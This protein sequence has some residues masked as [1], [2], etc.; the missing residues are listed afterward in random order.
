MGAGD[1]GFHLARI[2]A[3]EGHDITVVDRDPERVAR[4]HEHLDVMAVEGSGTRTELIGKLGARNADLLIAVTS[5]DEV[6][7]L[8]CMIAGKLGTHRRIARVSDYE[9]L[10]DES[11]LSPQDFNIDLTVYPEGIAANE[12]VRL[13]KRSTATDVLEFADG[14]I[15]IIGLRLDPSSPLINRKLSD[16]VK[17]YDTLVFRIVAISR[18]G[19][20]IIPTGDEVFRKNDQVFSVSKTEYVHEMLR[21]AGKEGEQLKTVMILGGG[22]IG[23]HV[24]ELLQEDSRVKLIES[25]KDVSQELAGKLE[26]TMVIQGEASDIDLLA[27]EGIHETD[28]YIAVTGDEETNIISCLM[29][30]HLGVKKTIALVENL[31]YLPL[32]GTIGLDVAVNKKLSAAHV[33]L[34]FVRKGEVVSVATLHGVDAEV[35]ELI[36]QKGS[37]ITRKPLKDIGFHHEAIVGCIIRDGDVIIPVGAS[38][39]NEGDRV[40]VFTLPQAIPKVEKLFSK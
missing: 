26:K 7:I 35:I 32:A 16:V 38:R 33:I 27:T 11:P 12:I 30:K 5:N 20:T 18:A 14:K 24:A 40:V 22:K 34:K 4:V 25:K 8:S 10:S 29:A 31:E 37:A 36:A 2:L 28:A 3:R 9:L 21:I 15:Q 23:R 39:I 1:V 13:I 17:D 19:R 6:N